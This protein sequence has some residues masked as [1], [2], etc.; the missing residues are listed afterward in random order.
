LPIFVWSASTTRRREAWI[1]A[2]F[3]P[4]SAG[5]GVVSPRSTEQPLVPRNAT[6]T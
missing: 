2:R 5:S 3:T 4:A 6:S 1:I